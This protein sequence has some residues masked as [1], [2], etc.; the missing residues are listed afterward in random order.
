VRRDAALLAAALPATLYWFPMYF[1]TWSR[2]TQLAGLVLVPVAWLLVERA[3][4]RP[5][6]RIVAAAALAA[7]GLA[8]THYRVTI[9]FAIG[10]VFLVAVA[11]L[12]VREPADNPPWRPALTVAAIAV[13]AGLLASPWLAGP[14]ADGLRHIAAAGRELAA[15]GGP[16][17]WYVTPSE[18]LTVPRWLVTQRA[19]A[20][21]MGLGVAGIVAGAVRGGWGAWWLMALVA[22]VAVAARPQVLSLPASWLLPGFSAAISL[23]VPVGLG[24]AHLADSVAAGIEAKLVASGTAVARL[25]RATAVLA[26]LAGG[27]TSQWVREFRP[28]IVEV[29]HPPTVLAVAADEAAG[30]WIAENTPPDSRFL[31]GAVLWHLG[32][33]R[34]VDGGYWLPLLAGRATTMPGGLYSFGDPDDVRAITAFAERVSATASPS[35]DALQALMDDSGA[36]Y[37]YVGPQGADVA[38]KWKPGD[39][40]ERPFLRTV[41][42][43]DGVFV[44]ARAR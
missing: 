36:D 37:I 33:Y 34:G 1:L 30:K 6:H 26:V 38:T 18:D 23:F 22:T 42:E 21:W 16:P 17:R 28:R 24:M 5:D 31:V 12:R 2:F 44:F 35:D 27:F 4:R 19:N 20:L 13:L 32:S 40:A 11:V 10:T 39:L 3:M 15:A 7:A 9:F 29:I 14:F 8:L 41:Y 25:V 43:R